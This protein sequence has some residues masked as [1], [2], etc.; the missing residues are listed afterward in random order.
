MQEFLMKYKDLLDQ[1]REGVDA[2][3][4]A[5]EGLSK[6]DMEF[7]PA[8]PEAWTIKEHIIHLVD[9]EVNGFIRCKSIIAQP[10]SVCYVMEEDSWTANIRRKNEDEGKY[11]QLFGL[12]RKMVY[13]LL[14]D[15]PDEN[16]NKDYFI[17]NY[18]GNKELV[19]IE[20][21]V[22]LYINHL[23]FHLEYIDKIRSEALVKLE[24]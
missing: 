19:T 18:K 6:N 14:I 13:D 8:R 11:L 16:W 21:C 7:R 10:N 1:Y 3:N 4:T 9:S 17:R 20:K 24:G 12:I 23:N 15:E 5:L 2:L 22:Q